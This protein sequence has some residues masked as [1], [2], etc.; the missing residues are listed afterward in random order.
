MFLVLEIIFKLF[1]QNIY[2]LK[3]VIN[4]LFMAIYCSAA[5]GSGRKLRDILRKG[6][7]NEIKGNK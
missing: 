3:L 2:K 7:R 6:K 4:Q 5:R 1:G